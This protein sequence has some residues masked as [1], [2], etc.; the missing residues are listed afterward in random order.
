M[1]WF[2]MIAGAVLFLLPFITGY[3]GNPAALWTSLI[4]GVVIAV[5]GYLKN[6]KLAAVSGLLTFIAPWIMSFSGIGA[7][8]WTCLIVGGAVAIVDGYRG[9]LSGRG[10]QTAQHA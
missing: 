3:S 2:T 9:F 4:M 1:N 6:Y 8:L 5:L 7:A 10:T